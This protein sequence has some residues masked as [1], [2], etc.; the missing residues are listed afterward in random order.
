MNGA[1]FAMALVVIAAIGGLFFLQW[2]SQQAARARATDPASQIGGG[3]GSLVSGLVGLA[4][5]GSGGAT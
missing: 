1:A 3:I 4:T 2:Q 5:S